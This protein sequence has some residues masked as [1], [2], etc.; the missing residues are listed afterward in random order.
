MLKAFN[1][2]KA[3]IVDL[4]DQHTYELKKAFA[5]DD[6]VKAAQEWTAQQKLESQ[7]AIDESVRSF[8]AGA[9]EAE[10][11]RRMI[12]IQ[13]TDITEARARGEQPKEKPPLGEIKKF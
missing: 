1:A 8:L 2:G 13:S 5:D 6:V 4:T 7:A 12:V 9:A 3:F 11:T 10:I